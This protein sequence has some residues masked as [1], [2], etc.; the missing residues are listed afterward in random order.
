MCWKNDPSI[1]LIN[2]HHHASPIYNFFLV[3]RV[4]FFSFGCTC[5]MQKF[6]GQGSNPSHS[7]NQSYSSDNSRSLTYQTTRELLLWGHLWRSTLVATF[8]YVYN[9]VLL[10]I[11]AMFIFSITRSF[12]LW[13]FLSFHHSLLPAS[14]NCQAVLC[15]YE[16][17]FICLFAFR[18]HIKVRSHGICLLWLASF[19]TVPLRCI[20][21]VTNGTIF[22]FFY[23]MWVR[24]VFPSHSSINGHFCSMFWIL[25]IML[26]WTWGYNSSLSNML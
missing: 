16:L 17:W 3:M 10:T 1:G 12:Y 25:Y 22:S 6:Q 18:F 5:G 15:T 7:S 19:S 24:H 9:T 13:L 26:Q 23:G 20:H 8:R 14:G 2:I 4:F 11:V 21:V